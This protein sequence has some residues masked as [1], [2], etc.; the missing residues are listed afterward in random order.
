M[1]KSSLS[2]FLFVVI[3]VTGNSFSCTNNTPLDA[4]KLGMF[5]EIFNEVKSYSYIKNTDIYIIYDC[6]KDKLGYAFFS[7]GEG[8]GGK[9]EILIGLRDMESIEGI[10]IV[11]HHE[12]SEGWMN[13]GW[14]DRITYPAF[15]KQFIGLSIDKCNL[16]KDNGW[17]DAI[18][19]ATISSQAVVDIVS[20]AV[21]EKVASILIAERN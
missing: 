9:M 11:Y 21:V 5:A 7:S 18:T 3:I 16:R 2:L 15:T 4:V 6:N 17:V 20:V 12:S 10:Y 14:G 1:I 19:G 13:V 8:Y